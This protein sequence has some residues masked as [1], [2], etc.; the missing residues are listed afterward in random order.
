MYNNLPETG[1]IRLPQLIGN[2]RTDPPIPPII[3]VKKSTLYMWIQRQ[4]FPAPVRL[5]ERCSAWRVEDV[6]RWIEQRR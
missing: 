6:R 2:P 5:G 4:E 1:F 3:P